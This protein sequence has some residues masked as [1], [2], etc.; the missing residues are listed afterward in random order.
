MD[1]WMDASPIAAMQDR[2]WPGT[3]TLARELRHTKLYV[4]VCATGSG[5]GDRAATGHVAD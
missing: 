2:S 4:C 3:E 1:G 5:R